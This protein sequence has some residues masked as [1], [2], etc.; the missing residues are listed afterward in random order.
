M[1]DDF[2]EDTL[3]DLVSEKEFIQ[4]SVIGPIAEMRRQKEIQNNTFF[5]S[6]ENFEKSSN[7]QIEAWFTKFD[8]VIIDDSN[9]P[10]KD[11]LTKKE[12]GLKIGKTIYNNLNRTNMQKGIGMIQKGTSMIS[13]FGNAFGNNRTSSSSKSSKQ[14]F[15]QKT[16]YMFLTNKPKRNSLKIWSDDIKPKTKHR[17]RKHVQFPKSNFLTDGKKIS[18]SSNKKVKFF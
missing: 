15:R 16:D 8:Q 6:R 17:K 12:I 14:R 7:E 13:E 18:F 4:E 5:I 1:S 11:P 3:E 10:Y 2:D 9:N